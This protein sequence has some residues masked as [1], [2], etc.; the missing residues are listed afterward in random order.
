M[1]ESDSLVEV[2]HIFSKLYHY[3]WSANEF[4]IDEF[5]KIKVRIPDTVIFKNC[6]PRFWYFTDSHGHIKKKKREN[7]DSDLIT[8]DFLK[9]P[10]RNGVVAYFI[11]AKTEDEEDDPRGNLNKG[12]TCV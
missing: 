1:I 7:H 11:K 3:L 9:K 6:Q 4:S 8:E 10:F 5:A 2:D 12:K